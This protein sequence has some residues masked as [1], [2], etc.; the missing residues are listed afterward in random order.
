MD[1]LE[2]TLLVPHVTT[3]PVLGGWA[4]LCSEHGALGPVW[5]SELGAGYGAM[6]H[7]AVAHQG[8]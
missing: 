1:D 6:G 5:G 8:R 7:A 3:L 4:T 2:P